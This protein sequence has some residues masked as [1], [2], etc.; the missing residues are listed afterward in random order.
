[1]RYIP[2]GGLICH[3]VENVGW[4]GQVRFL[5]GVLVGVWQYGREARQRFHRSLY[6]CST[7]GTA[8]F[9]DNLV[10]SNY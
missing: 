10:I 1:M 7:H 5:G 3:S 8:M 4:S 6:P 9:L 2:D